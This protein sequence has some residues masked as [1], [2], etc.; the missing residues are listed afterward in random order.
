MKMQLWE[1]KEQVDE[2]IDRHGDS[3]PLE[4]RVDMLESQGMSR[5]IRIK[6]DDKSLTEHIDDAAKEG[7]DQGWDEGFKE[8]ES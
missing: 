7:F 4:L 5:V 2:M 3:A 8:G 1:L 6:L